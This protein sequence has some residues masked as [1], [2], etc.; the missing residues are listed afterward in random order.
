MNA[1]GYPE[2][3]PAIQFIEVPTKKA[4][5]T[6]YLP[7]IC[8]IDALETMIYKNEYRLFKSTRGVDGYVPSFRHGVRGTPMRENNYHVIDIQRTMAVKVHTDAAPT[9]KVDGMLTKARSTLH[10]T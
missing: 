2:N 6:R 7:V 10:G 5:V 3:A 4:G 9:T 8:P 1:V